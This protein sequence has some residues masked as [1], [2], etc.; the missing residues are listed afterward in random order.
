MSKLINFILAPWHAALRGI[1]MNDLW[2]TCKRVAVEQD[3]SLDHAK[4]AFATHALHDPAW[5]CLGEEEVIRRIDA[6]R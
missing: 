4:A 6:L 2:P 3:L 5:M 1:D